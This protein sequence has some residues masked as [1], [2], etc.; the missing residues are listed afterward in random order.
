MADN[1]VFCSLSRSG[2][3][4]DNAAMERFFSSLKSERTARKTHRTRDE[5][6]PDVFDSIERLN[7]RK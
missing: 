4:S 7:S 3:V 1:G 2:K 6:K 5:A